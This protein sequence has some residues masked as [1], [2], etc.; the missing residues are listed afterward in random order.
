MY[1]SKHEKG[2]VTSHEVKNTH[3]RT[4]KSGKKWLYG[5]AALA[6]TL[7]PISGALQPFLNQ[8]NLAPIKVKAATAATATLN[9]NNNS[10]A[11]WDTGNHSYSGTEFANTSNYNTYGSAVIA[12]NWINLTSGATKQVGLGIFNGSV[13]SI[14]AATGFSLSAQIKID[15]G[16]VGSWESA[17]DDIGIILTGASKNQ[18]QANAQ[19]TN[20]SG[21]NLGIAGLPNTVFLGRDLYSNLTEYPT[22][23]SVI[24]GMDGQSFP[25][26]N[27]WLPGSGNMMVIRT[28]DSSGN[29]IQA[30]YPALGSYDDNPSAGKQNTVFSNTSNGWAVTMAGDTNAAGL[31]N[32]VITEPISITWTPDATNAAATGFTSGTLSET[33]TTFNNYG[34][35]AGLGGA[36]T[37]WTIKSH[38]NLQNS[39]S[40][41]FVGATGGNSG[42]LSVSLNGA[43]IQGAKGTEPVQVNYVNAKTGLPISG[44]TPSMINANVNDTIGVAKTGANTTDTYTYNTPTA[45]PTGFT[46][47]QSIVQGTPT[48]P[49][50]S[51]QTTASQQVT[52]FIQGTTNPN[53]LTVAYAPDPAKVWWSY[54]WA[55]NTYGAFM[56]SLTSLSQTGNFGDKI[57]APTINVPAGYH[58]SAIKEVNGTYLYYPGS[59]QNTTP[60]GTNWVDITQTANGAYPA[61]TAGLEQAAIDKSGGTMLD[62]NGADPGFNTGISSTFNNQFGIYLEANKETPA[63]TYAYSGATNGSQPALPANISLPGGFGQPLGLGNPSNWSQSGTTY[64]ASLDSKLA[65]TVPAGMTISSIT[66]PNGTNYDKVTNYTAPTATSAGS[67]TLEV[68]G[69]TSTQ[70]FTVKYQN[71]GANPVPSNTSVYPTALSTNA[72]TALLQ[73]LGLAFPYGDSTIS[74]TTTT[75]GSGTSAAPYVV[76]NSNN[77]FVI[78]LAQTFTGSLNDVWANN[79]PGTNGNA[80][81]LQGSL[82]APYQLPSGAAGTAITFPS[83]WG[84]V[85]AGYSLVAPVTAAATITSLPAGVVSNAMTTPTGLTFSN[86]KFTSGTFAQATLTTKSLGTTAYGIITGTTTSYPTLSSASTISNVASLNAN[87]YYSLVIF[88]ADGS[89]LQVNISPATAALSN[90]TIQQL[91]QRAYPSYN[92]TGNNYSVA[93]QANSYK[94]TWSYI[95]PDGTKPQYIVSLTDKGVGDY[96]GQLVAPQTGAPLRNLSNWVMG[97]YGIPDTLPAGTFIQG[98]EIAYDKTGQDVNGNSLATDPDNGE[99]IFPTFAALKAKYPVISSTLIGS[100]AAGN[101]ITNA[102]INVLVAND[103]TALSANLD[104]TIMQ[105]NT[106][107]PLNDLTGSNNFDNSTNANDTTVNGQTNNVIMTIQEA[108]I[109]WSGTGNYIGGSSIDATTNVGNPIN[110]LDPNLAVNSLKAGNYLVAYYTLNKAGTLAYQIWLSNQ[111]LTASTAN[112]I[113]FFNQLPT[114]GENGDGLDSTGTA[115][116]TDYTTSTNATQNQINGV[117]YFPDYSI[118]NGEVINTTAVTRLTVL[119]PFD[120]PFTGGEGLAG[121]VLVATVAGFGAIS[122]KKKKNQEEQETFDEK[123]EDKK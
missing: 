76:T 55:Y 25:V 50:T 111:S 84:T 89:Y 15:N 109:D 103:Q 95:L 46:G 85:P 102:D 47:I 57:T 65:V 68:A 21:G 77:Q 60:S 30:N 106:Y 28:T 11:G 49:V 115:L 39:L 42:K 80:G 12:G 1:H 43:T 63:I 116:F 53:V 9:A 78:N 107:H 62:A 44:M 123:E 38:L 20:A 29:L 81:Q 13:S 117:N 22:V 33:I 108:N 52:N 27:L 69:G 64:T 23:N 41:G 19:S 40:V 122:L 110:A 71:V 51:S 10:G 113:A 100:T 59:V 73:A 72:N 70:T 6:L 101:D 31:T 82:P 120:L 32:M 118:N 3:F 114:S 93:I 86:L 26:I 16:L 96:S 105:G 5:S 54:N 92:A 36:P 67:V 91:L 121:I 75:T 79:T 98:Y 104:T 48:Y 18:L 8:S 4:W 119:P 35:I 7:A 112:L 14:S 97:K 37:S 61:T 74:T 2:Y 90:F 94:Q 45:I 17:G 66:A 88:N 58:V 87:V 56:G 83:S 24:Q 34:T 99:T